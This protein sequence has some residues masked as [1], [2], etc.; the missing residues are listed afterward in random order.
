M[1]EQLCECTSGSSGT[2][3][4]WEPN[5]SCITRCSLTLLA[6][7]APNVA[8]PIFKAPAVQLTPLCANAHMVLKQAWKLVEEHQHFCTVCAPPAD[9]AAHK[10][11]CAAALQQGDEWR[12][13]WGQ[14]GSQAAGQPGSWGGCDGKLASLPRPAVAST[15]PFMPK[16]QA[17][18]ALTSRLSAG[19]RGPCRT[20]QLH[21]PNT[22]AALQ[23]V[24][25]ALMANPVNPLVTCLAPP[26]MDSRV[27]APVCACP[28]CAVVSYTSR[29]GMAGDAGLVGK[30]GLVF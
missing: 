2:H 10:P 6:W 5:T 30:G 3:D 23:E 29:A 9:H 20:I 21:I 11:K 26:S 4:A 28:S 7:V 16:P 22:V 14:V 13:V 25:S 19:P 18:T 8:A 24:T 1:P 27:A 15:H 17:L 12:G